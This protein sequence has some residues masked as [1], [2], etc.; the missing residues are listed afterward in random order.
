[1]SNHSNLTH[2]RREEGFVPEHCRCALL[3]LLLYAASVSGL[4]GHAILMSATPETKQ[5]VSGPDVP[6]SLRFNCRID[7]KRSRITL[8]TPGGNQV[9][10]NIAKQASADTLNSEAKE[11]KRGSYV[12]RWQ[13]LANDGH[14]TRGEVPFQVQ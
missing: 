3:V 2:L 7:A 5:V 8:V 12:L 14:I 13:V 10:L 4:F 9:A 11:L 1:M 6:I